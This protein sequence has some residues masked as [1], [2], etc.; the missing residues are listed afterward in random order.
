[1]TILKT[2]SNSGAQML[3]TEQVVCLIFRLGLADARTIIEVVCAI[4]LHE[5]RKNLSL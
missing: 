5:C 4:L 1:M 2:D 3:Y